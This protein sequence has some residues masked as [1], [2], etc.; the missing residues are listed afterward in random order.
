VDF[1]W[2]F[3][4]HSFPPQF[5]LELMLVNYVNDVGLYEYW[6]MNG[7]ML[8]QTQSELDVG[9]QFLRKPCEGWNVRAQLLKDSN[10]RDLSVAVAFVPKIRQRNPLR[11]GF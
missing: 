11:L 2:N 6:L 9:V 3:W 8:C 1:V 4:S 7:M 5:L 10:A